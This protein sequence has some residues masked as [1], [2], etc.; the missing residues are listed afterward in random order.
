LNDHIGRGE[1][2]FGEP[3]TRKT[4]LV[5]G[6]NYSLRIRWLCPDPNI[7][8]LGVARMTVRGEGI[9]PNDEKSN[10]MNGEGS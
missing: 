1:V 7:E 10:V 5:E 3:K 4:E 6:A 9:S 8:V 2:F